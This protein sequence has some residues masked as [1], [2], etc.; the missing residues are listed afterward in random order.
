M[1]LLGARSLSRAQP[2]IYERNAR[3]NG[4]C[5]CACV[6]VRKTVSVC[7]RVCVV[8][9][10]HLSTPITSDWWNVPEHVWGHS[11]AERVQ[12]ARRGPPQSKRRG[13]EYAAINK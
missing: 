13:S 1:T 8:L 12:S 3:A 5:M 2:Y 6:R 7:W 4:V 11:T 9:R 10:A